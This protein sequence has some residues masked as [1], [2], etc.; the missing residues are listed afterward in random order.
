M[1]SD[2]P[3]WLRLL[4]FALVTL[5]VVAV[6][7]PWVWA[8]LSS[9]KARGDIMAPGFWP[10]LWVPENYRRLLGET[11]YLRWLANSAIVAFSAALL[12]VLIC[13]MAAYALAKHRFI[14]RG[15]LFWVVIASMSIPP[16][17]TII[18]LFGWAA[19]LGIIDTYGVV[20]VPFAASALGLFLI[21]QYMLGIPDELIEAARIDGAGEWLIF[22]RIMAPLARPALGT[23]GILIFVAAWN[24]YLW[25]LVMM[26]SEEMFTLPV[27]IAGL[28]SEQTPEYGMVMAAAVLSSLPI[29]TVFLLLQKQLVAGL[30]QGAVKG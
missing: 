22:R 19:Q 13:A 11:L 2:I 6:M 8:L 20:V 17:T 10:R 7:M 18:P 12:G 16:F 21:R 29:V 25:P 23:A 1:R 24:A 30:T 4:L 28:N 3:A 15:A 5:L 27:G 26:R 9:F 14:G